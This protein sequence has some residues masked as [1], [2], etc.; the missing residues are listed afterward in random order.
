MKPL[1]LTLQAFGPFATTENVDFTKLGRNPLFLINGPTGSGKTSILDAICFALYGETTGNERQGGQMRCDQAPLTLPTEVTLEFALNERR[2]RV[3]RSPEQEAP[4]ARGEGTT[5]RKHTASLYEITDD[6]RLITSKT[7][8][9]KTE[10]TELLGLNETQFRQVMVLPQGKFRELLLASSKDREAIFGQLFQTDMYKKIEYALKDRAASISK[11]KGEF[12]NQIRG[13]LQVAEVSS[14][15]ELV[16][17]KAQLTEV[18]SEAQSAEKV[19]LTALN[20]VKEQRQKA[21]SLN[22]QFTKLS[23]TK[24]LLAKHLE[25]QNDVEVWKKSLEQAIKANKLDVPYANW[26]AALKQVQESQ[27]KLTSLTSEQEQAKHTLEKAASQLV[28]A[29]KAAEQTTELTEQEYKLEQTKV[30]FAEKLELEA[31]I[32]A[33]SDQQAD[34]QVKLTQYDALKEKLQRE[35][36]QGTKQLAQARLDVTEKL[37]LSATIERGQRLHADLTKL[38]ALELALVNLDKQ[39]SVKQSQVSIAEQTLKTKRQEADQ[40]ELTWH[41]AQAAILAQKLEQDAPCPVCGSCD[42]PA[43]AS[44]SGDEVSKE[45]V[46]HARENERV[47]LEQYNLVNGQLRQHQHQIEQQQDLVDTARKALG[48]DAQRNLKQL[49]IELSTQQ[50]RLKLLSAIDINAMEQQVTELNQRCS[51]GEEKINAL[52][53]EISATLSALSLKQEQ[54]IKL[55]ENIDPSFTT[56]DVI[57]QNI[58]QIK[59]QITKLKQALEAAQNI[60]QKAELAK[61]NLETQFATHTEQLHK[62]RIQLE[63]AEKQW[64]TALKQAELDSEQAYLN[65]RATEQQ[66]NQWQGDIAQFEQS[67]VQFEQT[68]KDLSES[69]QNVEQPDID[70]ISERLQKVEAEYQ[71]SREALDNARSLYQRVEKV[72]QDIRDLH[73]KNSQLEAEYKVYGTLYDV[74]SGKTGSRISLHR[75]VLGVLLDDVLIQASQRLSIMSRG[76]YQLVRKTEGFKGSAGRGLD[77]SVEDGY[78]GKTRDVATLSGGESFMAALALALGLSDVVQSYSGGIRLDTLFIDEGFGSLDP[79]SLDLAM[80]IL[81]DLQQSGR[82]IGV[83]SH[84]SELKEQMQL[85]LDVTPSRVGSSLKLVGTH[86]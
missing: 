20:K 22:E 30:K 37:T 79:E 41:S 43:P 28:E 40:L 24:G 83:I 77:L 67:K 21:I 32:K 38:S 9:V 39:T 47:A 26:Q 69:T 25:S 44:F 55:A 27:N 5:V 56:L 42:H 4:K 11:A 33:L 63:E 62:G 45:Q 48:K 7:A 13:A 59:Q 64:A 29:Q 54:H 60:N 49:E 84:I 85:R 66:I 14:E 19:Q 1:L 3:T 34:Q 72:Q 86:V 80:Q 16:E 36:E 78:T 68:I 52:K 6:E 31:S 61:V 82:T 65:V 2:Y 51:N 74:A 70:A 12:D 73:E 8:Q 35:A 75:F 15:Q 18:F 57:D 17:R 53:G 76:R 50:E 23:N 10:V 81:I 58:S 71:T 46:Q